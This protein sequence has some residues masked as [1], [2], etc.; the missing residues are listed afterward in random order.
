MKGFRAPYLSYNQ[1]QLEILGS[2]GFT[3]DSSITE[4]FGKYSNDIGGFIW[5]YTHDVLAV[6]N[7]WTGPFTSRKVEGLFEIP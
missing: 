3:Y 1:E 2:L 5:P 7:D 4:G 6:Q